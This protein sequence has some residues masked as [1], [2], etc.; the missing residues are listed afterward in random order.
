MT[1]YLV[2]A[3]PGHRDY[4]TLRAAELLGRADV[5][6]HDDLVDADV[7]A[8]AAPW[9]E[10][11]PAGKRGGKRSADQQWINDVLID[12]AAGNEC[13]VRLKGGD[14]H[15]FGRAAEEAMACQAAGIDV[16]IVA[17]VSSAVAGPTAVGIP[18]TNRHLSSGFT[19]L[20][21]H[22]DPATDHMINWDAVAQLGTTLV[23]LMG[24]SRSAAIG[25]RLLTGGM[26]PSTPVAAVTDATLPTQREVRTTLGALASENG[27]TDVTIESPAVLIIGAVAAIDLRSV[28]SAN[29]AA[30]A[31][32][33]PASQG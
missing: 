32:T 7:L 17:G 21:A 29:F 13:V 18:L 27:G 1:V 16:E 20:T 5:V 10:M 28:G 24:A 30:F 23:I 4:L 19:V 11:I 14:P 26:D 3:G 22:Q 12:R 15:V 33:V 31:N 8:L 6:V 9:A 2:G 25:R